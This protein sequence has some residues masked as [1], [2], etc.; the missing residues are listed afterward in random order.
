M[1][2]IQAGL[3]CALIYYVVWNVDM[4][5]GWQTLSRPIVVAPITGLLLGDFKIGIMMGA[6]L[7]SLYMGVSAIGGVVPADAFTS[8]IIA[9]A[10]SILTK[11]DMETGLA[12]ALPIGTIMANLRIVTKT[13]T[14]LFHP[15]FYR[16]AQNGETKKYEIG[17][18]LY[19]FTLGSLINF[20]I[21]FFAVAFGVA[22]LETLLASFPAFVL[23]GFNAA[24]GMMTVVG[25]ALLS[26]SIWSMETSFYV[27]LGFIL[28]KYLGLDSLVIAVVA[29]IICAS[30]YFTEMKIQNVTK[31]NNVS[32]EEDDFYA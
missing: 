2:M 20:S 10:F 3:L 19:D 29:A 30:K 4:L 17:L 23:K 11:S 9:V 32:E 12:I 28:S 22:G 1:N 25:L 7:E 8:S 21:I 27:L 16:L 26:V 24:G 31:L 14:S 13:I 15:L 18:F 5:F 6:S